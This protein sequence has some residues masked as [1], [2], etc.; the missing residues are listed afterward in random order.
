MADLDLP[1]T[2]PQWVLKPGSGKVG[3]DG[4]LFQE[5]SPVAPLGPH[6]CLVEFEAVSLNYRDVAILQG[7]YPWTVKDE[8]VPVSDGAGTVVAVGGSVQEFSEGDKVCTLFHQGWQRG[9]L[10]PQAR[11]TTLGTHVGGVLRRYAVFP[12]KG[13]VASP[14]HLTAVEACTLPCAAVTAWNALFG[15]EGRALQKGQTVLVQGTGGVSL[16]ALQFAIATG[17]TVIATTSSEAK[18]QKLRQEFG[19]HHVI[20]YKKDEQWGVTAKRLSDDSEGVHHII[21]VGGSS[22]MQQ[23]LQAIRI[24]GLI[25]LIGF[26]G[27]KDEKSPANFGDCLAAL[28]VLRG[29]NVGSKEQFAAMNEF[30]TAH[31]IK[32]VVD[33]NIFRFHQAKEAYRFLW[34]Q[35]QWGKV[36][37]RME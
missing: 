14:R 35:R 32:P 4:L 13:L 9:P 30:M 5:S 36:V 25:S 2:T 7:N 10:T 17:A 1:K 33:G 15:L 3:F 23:S 6:D 8:V 27:G 37:I 20:N 11:L 19:V 31:D 24:E 29:V 21:E 16:F 22:S 18:A 28:C 26:L 34:E 12:E